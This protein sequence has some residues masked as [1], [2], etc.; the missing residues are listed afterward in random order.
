VWQAG[1]ATFAGL[2]LFS[3]RLRVWVVDN[4]WPETVPFALAVGRLVNAEGHA[5]VN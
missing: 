5:M 1:P 3:K 2:E 4:V